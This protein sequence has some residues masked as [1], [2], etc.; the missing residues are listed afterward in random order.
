ML[1]LSFS[2]EGKFP[3]P[4]PYLLCKIQPPHRL[5]YSG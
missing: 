5:F 2:S 4:Q 1:L 3:F